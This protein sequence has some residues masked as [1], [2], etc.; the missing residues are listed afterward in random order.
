MWAEGSMLSVLKCK[1]PDFYLK[2]RRYLLQN[3][4]RRCKIIQER[5]FSVYRF[6]VLADQL[7]YGND[8]S[9]S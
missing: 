3:I 9:H 6:T 7:F 1:N 4:M 8:G 5:S 2:W